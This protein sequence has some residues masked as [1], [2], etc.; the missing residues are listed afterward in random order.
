MKHAK[1]FTLIELLV[2]IAIIGILA[3]I[4]LPAL[5]RAREAA[6]RASCQNNLKQW[7]LVYKMYA[8]ESAGSFPPRNADANG[9]YVAYMQVYP[10]YLTDLTILQCQS[11]SEGVGL[12]KDVID[13][14]SEN[15]IWNSEGRNVIREGNNDDVEGARTYSYFYL[16][17]AMVGV[18]DNDYHMNYLDPVT[19]TEIDPM[20]ESDDN[21]F[22]SL[23]VVNKS[24][25]NSLGVKGDNTACGLSLVPPHVTWK[26]FYQVYGHGLD[27]PAKKHTDANKEGT[28]QSGVY[29]AL[30]EGVERFAITDVFNPAGSAA[31]Q[32]SIPVMLD[33]IRLQYGSE[34]FKNMAYCNH[35]PG[36]SNV[37]YMDGHVEFKKYAMG[38]WPVSPDFG[39]YYEE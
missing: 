26:G 16:G 34:G 2:V 28:G 1:G 11:N 7:G 4:L 3:A 33:V 22:K 12:I 25:L 5:A 35:L 30:R 37:L 32:S 39:P 36:G 31:G 10:E 17:Y 9:Q 8:N 21:L 24:W 19:R 29:Y 27:V 20:R 6:R 38:N 23:K 18:E 14:I 13:E 15:G